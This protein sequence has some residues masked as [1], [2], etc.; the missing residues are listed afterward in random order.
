MISAP[1]PCRKSSGRRAVSEGKSSRLLGLPSL[2]FMALRYA[3][4]R[5]SE[6]S[7]LT[8]KIVGI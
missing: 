5:D 6:L 2:A 4:T 7:T 8:D 1:V 3:E